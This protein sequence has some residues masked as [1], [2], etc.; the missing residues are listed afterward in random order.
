MADITVT[1]S[2]A[3]PHPHREH[4]VVY[5]MKE[6]RLKVRRV[7]LQAI[8]ACGIVSDILTA[9]VYTNL[10]HSQ[11]SMLIPVVKFT[12]PYSTYMLH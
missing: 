3:L 9:G 1:A 6:N 12:Y 11:I 7:Q 8:Y 10:S 5:R 4:N 2:F